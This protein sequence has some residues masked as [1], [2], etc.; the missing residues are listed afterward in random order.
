MKCVT[1]WA[2]EVLSW[3]CFDQNRPKMAPKE[4]ELDTEFAVSR[5]TSDGKLG[6]LHHDFSEIGLNVNTRAVNALVV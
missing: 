4:V 1:E 3:E 6:F 2:K 5:S